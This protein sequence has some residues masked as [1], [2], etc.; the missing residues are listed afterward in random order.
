MINDLEPEQTE[1]QRLD[2]A[3]RT[4]LTELEYAQVHALIILAYVREQESINK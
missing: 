4:H 2:K 3:L 1:I